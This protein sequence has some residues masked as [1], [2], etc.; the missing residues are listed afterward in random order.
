MWE[1]HSVVLCACCSVNTPSTKRL[2]ECQAWL[3]VSLIV[4][5]FIYQ[6][7]SYGRNFIFC[8]KLWVRY[9]VIRCELVLFSCRFLVPSACS[10]QTRTSPQLWSPRAL[11]CEQHWGWKSP[12][13]K[14]GCSCSSSSSEFLLFLFTSIRPVGLNPRYLSF[15]TQRFS[16]LLFSFFFF[17]NQSCSSCLFFLCPQCPYICVFSK[18]L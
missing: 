2:F 13:P 14:L 6:Q 3:W 8:G 10:H 9:P 18:M 7:T 17:L 1:R 15:T 16:F 11:L 5:N 12:S 4:S